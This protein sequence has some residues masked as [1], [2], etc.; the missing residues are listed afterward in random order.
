MNHILLFLSSD[1]IILLFV[2]SVKK[3]YSWELE[4]P[5][6]AVKVTQVSGIGSFTSYLAV[7]WVQEFCVKSQTV[8]KTTGLYDTL[9][10][11]TAEVLQVVCLCCSVVP[12][13]VKSMSEFNLGSCLSPLT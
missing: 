9:Y 3:N 11:L 6:P 1:T 2:D 8:F 5:T 12:V 10:G 13:C 4:M 7:V